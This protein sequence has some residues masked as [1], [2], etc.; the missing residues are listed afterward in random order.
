VAIERIDLGACDGCF[1][2]R[3][4][5]AIWLTRRLSS[6]VVEI[7][8]ADHGLARLEDVALVQEAV[9]AFVESL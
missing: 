1:Y 7:H 8:G 9:G 2:P 4:E 5:V 6:G 3:A